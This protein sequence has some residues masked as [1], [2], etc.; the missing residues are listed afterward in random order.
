MD[1]TIK[2]LTPS[3]INEYLHFFDN[4]D[5]HE[6]GYKC[7]CVG[8]SSANYSGED[9][10]NEKV[11]RNAVSDYIKENYIQG[12]LA[13]YNDKIIGWCNANEKSNCF[14]SLYGKMY[15]GDIKKENE[16][17]KSIFC[18]VVSPEFRRKGVA[19]LILEY[20][21]ND[22]KNDG[23]EFIESYPNKEFESEAF[24]YMGPL[25]LYENLGFNYS[26]DF[27]FKIVMRKKL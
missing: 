27:D 11:R 23:F 15:M 24:D 5:H 25:K 9:F 14:N 10:K 13:F 3:L 2:K 21:I 7:Y 1:I 22:A 18:F 20:I 17:V 26:Y 12:Y 16:K 6:D 4:T 19:K 8:W